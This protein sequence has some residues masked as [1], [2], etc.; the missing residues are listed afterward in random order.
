MGRG[1]LDGTLA[2]LL[3]LVELA[4]LRH[5]FEYMT[6]R[7]LDRRDQVEDSWI[8]LRLEKH[9]YETHAEVRTAYNSMA[10]EIGRLDLL[11]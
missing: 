9:H 10:T 6:A 2:R 11:L 3:L 7:G 5:V 8:L 1:R 4:E